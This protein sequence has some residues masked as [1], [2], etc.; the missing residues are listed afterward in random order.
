VRKL[1]AREPG[2]LGF[3]RRRDAAGPQR[4]GEEPSPM[5]HEPEKSDSVIVA[6]KP[7]NK[8]E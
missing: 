2:G 7:T 4:E 5:M 8:A 3:D 1:F 6:A